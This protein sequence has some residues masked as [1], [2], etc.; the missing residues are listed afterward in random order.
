MPLIFNPA[1]YFMSKEE[2]PLII[3]LIL[4]YILISFLLLGTRD[5][6]FLK[7]PTNL[8]YDFLLYKKAELTHKI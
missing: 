4:S 3:C 8:I 6:F 2:F 1:Y 7:K 5:F